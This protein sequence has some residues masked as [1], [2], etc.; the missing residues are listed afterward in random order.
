MTTKSNLEF[1]IQT[2]ELY[3]TKPGGKCIDS[4]AKSHD[5]NLRLDLKNLKSEWGWVGPN[6]KQRTK[7]YKK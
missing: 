3:Q 4:T 7:I 5:Q 6:E 1:Q 2:T